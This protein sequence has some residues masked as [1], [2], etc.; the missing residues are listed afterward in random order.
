MTVRER[1][2]AIRLA[3]KINKTEESKAYAEKLGIKVEF[4]NKS[5]DKERKI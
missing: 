2:L 1:I 5:E 3:E 4:E